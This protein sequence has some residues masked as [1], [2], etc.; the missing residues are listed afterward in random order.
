MA[1]C[2]SRDK[3]SGS[4]IHIWQPPHHLFSGSLPTLLNPSLKQSLYR[5]Q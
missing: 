4:L 2:L 1:P 5:F 3:I